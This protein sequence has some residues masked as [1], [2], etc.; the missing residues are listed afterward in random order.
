MIMPFINSTSLAENGGSFARVVAGR[1]FDGWPGAP[2]WMT[3]GC[4]PITGSEERQT[5]T[6]VIPQAATDNLNR[7]LK[8]MQKDGNRI[9]GK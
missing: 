4:W 1:G 6:K 9:D 7:D 5:A 8:I 2:G 3:T